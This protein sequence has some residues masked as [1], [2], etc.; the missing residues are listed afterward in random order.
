MNIITG[1]KLQYLC[2]IY[3][4]EKEF[5]PNAHI[6]NKTLYLDKCIRLNEI[7][8]NKLL[9][10]KATKI[11]IYTHN[12]RNINDFNVFLKH[13]QEKKNNFILVLHNSDDKIDM[14]Y[15]NILETTKCVKIF[16]QNVCYMHQRIQYLPIGIA[17]SK[18]PHGNKKLLCDIINRSIKKENKIFF[19]FSIGTNRNIRYPCYNYFKNILTYNRSL[20]QKDYLI[21]LK[22]C[23]FCICPEGN[24]PDTHRF[25]ECL[26]LNVI[27]ICKRSPFIE[28]I[29]KDFPVCIVNEWSDLI[30]ND[31]FYKTYDNYIQNLNINKLD[32]NYWK[33]KIITSLE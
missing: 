30:I 6:Y 22:K 26:Y 14:K 8:N 20:P 23:K 27:P 18:W 24:G 9:F 17:N 13:L 33:N 21:N 31:G 19:N 15:K 2:D 12:L 28:N 29:N 16:G 10:L 4:G 11:S 32:F 5:N 25:W 3:I 7:K 1:E